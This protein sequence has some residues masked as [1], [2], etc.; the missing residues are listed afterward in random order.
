M[1]RLGITPPPN[2]PPAHRSQAHRF[3][4]SLMAK[5]NCICNHR[6]RVTLY[7][8]YQIKSA[9]KMKDYRCRLAEMVLLQWTACMELQPVMFS[10][11][12]RHIQM[13]RLSSLLPYTVIEQHHWFNW[14]MVPMGRMKQVINGFRQWEWKSLP[15]IKTAW[16]GKSQC[17]LLALLCFSS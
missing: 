16:V 15:M 13:L 1:T 11:S 17:K 14:P 7:V 2:P 9:A 5:L 4:M 12:G 3:L 8:T 6:R 10:P